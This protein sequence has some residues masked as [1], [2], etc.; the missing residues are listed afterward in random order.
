[1]FGRVCY[2]FGVKIGDE[3]SWEKMYGCVPKIGCCKVALTTKHRKLRKYGKKVKN[4]LQK[5]WSVVFNLRTIFLQNKTFR[6][7]HPKMPWGE[8][9]SRTKLLFPPAFFQAKNTSQICYTNTFTLFWNYWDSE[10]L[11]SHEAINLWNWWYRISSQ[12]RNNKSIRQSGGRFYLMTVLLRAWA[13]FRSLQYCE[14]K[15]VCMNGG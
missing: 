7:K 8:S 2:V 13:P 5:T 12:C 14:V 9:H 15:F 4:F 11:K 6:G 1:M 3:Y 10:G